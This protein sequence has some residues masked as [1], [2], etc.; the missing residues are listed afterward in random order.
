MAVERTLSIVKPDAV[1]ANPLGKIPALIRDDGAEFPAGNANWSQPARINL[2]Q[3]T[4]F[5][6]TM[7]PSSSI[8]CC[9]IWTFAMSIASYWAPIMAG[10]RSPTAGS[11][12]QNRARRSA[13][14]SQEAAR[15]LAGAVSYFN[16]PSRRRSSRVWSTTL[17]SRLAM[18]RTACLPFTPPS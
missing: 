2:R 8:G 12:A 18:Y 4:S 9:G 10:A 11:P 14:R 3:T 13:T 6:H 17:T 16:S 7:A 1:A 15:R 5:A